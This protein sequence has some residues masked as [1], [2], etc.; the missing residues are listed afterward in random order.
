MSTQERKQWKQTKSIQ[1]FTRSNAIQIWDEPVNSYVL[2]LMLIYHVFNFL[3]INN[4]FLLFKALHTR[5]VLIYFFKL[6]CSA[7]CHT[8]AF[9]NC[10]GATEKLKWQF[11]I[12]YIE[13]WR[14]RQSVRLARST[15]KCNACTVVCERQYNCARTRHTHTSIPIHI[16]RFG[17]VSQNKISKIELVCGCW[18]YTMTMNEG[19]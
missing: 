8:T 11:R 4:L 19:R 18:Y 5:F 1:N 14:C 16:F 7:K 15:S 3:T 9:V 10:F 17:F 2:K 12:M 6:K 13:V